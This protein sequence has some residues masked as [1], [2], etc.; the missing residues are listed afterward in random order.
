[1]N[2]FKPRPFSMWLSPVEFGVILTVAMFIVN[3]IVV[4][5]NNRLLNEL[6]DIHRLK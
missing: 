1:M 3:T 2:V 6:I 4:I 5:Q